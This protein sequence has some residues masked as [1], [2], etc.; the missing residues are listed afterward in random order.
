MTDGHGGR[1]PAE[2]QLWILTLVRLG[3]IGL[4]LF[5]LWLAGTSQGDSAMMAGGLALMAMGGAD[6]LLVPRLLA[7]RWKR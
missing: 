5:G 1:D 6:V 2:R 3:G 4:I 7:R